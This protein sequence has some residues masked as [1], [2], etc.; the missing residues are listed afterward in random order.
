MSSY[1]AF[2]W[3]YVWGLQICYMNWSDF[4]YFHNFRLTPFFQF[5]G[6][7]IKASDKISGKNLK[8]KDKEQ[9]VSNKENID[10]KKC[11]CY[12]FKPDS[13]AMLLNT[14]SIE[15]DCF[16]LFKY[17]LCFYLK[18]KNL[19]YSIFLNRWKPLICFDV[20]SLNFLEL[21]KRDLN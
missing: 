2:E 11:Q 1:E 5:K 13:L 20:I 9:I 14:D 10:L 19:L 12:N 8:L 4:W 15:S 3:E 7:P 16:A 21:M 6:V 18:S 17:I